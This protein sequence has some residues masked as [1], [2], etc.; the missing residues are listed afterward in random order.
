MLNI[1]SPDKFKELSDT[2]QKA[3]LQWIQQTLTP[4]KTINKQYSSYGLKH[5]FEADKK[6]GGFYITNGAFKGAMLKAG[7]KT[8]YPDL[9]TNW[10]FNISKIRRVS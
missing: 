6:H 4:R 1:N 5:I 2:D 8:V 9:N 3:L 7:F 10:E